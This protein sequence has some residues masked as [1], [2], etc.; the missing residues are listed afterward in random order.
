MVLDWDSQSKLQTFAN[1]VK[2]PDG[3]KAL[4]WPKDAFNPRLGAAFK[5]IERVYSDRIVNRAIKAGASIAKR[6]DKV[7]VVH[8]DDYGE[9]KRNLA[10]IVK[11]GL[12]PKDLER[13]RTFI[14]RVLRVAGA[15]A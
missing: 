9:V 13:S 10:R 14:E 2:P 8:S 7:L 11:E 3:Y 5:G 4:V 15:K 1:L 12:R 6:K